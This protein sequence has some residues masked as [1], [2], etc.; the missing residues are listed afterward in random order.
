MEYD[1][2]FV[3]RN[4]YYFVGGFVG[5]FVVYELIKAAG[6]SS[7]SDNTDTSGF[8]NASGGPVNQLQ[9]S[10]DIAASGNNAAIQ[11]ANYHAQ[12]SDN[13]IAAELALG[14]TQAATQLA[15]SL[16][17][18]S[19]TRDVALAQTTADV[20]KTALVTQ[21]AVDIQSIITGG[22]VK[23]TQI[24]GKTLTD[25]SA[26]HIALQTHMLDIVGSQIAQIQAH[27]KH[28]SQDYTAI[29][30]ILAIETGQQSA[31]AA[32]AAANAAD[33]TAASAVKGTAIVAGASVINQ[34]T[35]TSGTVF[36]SIAKGL[37]G[38]GGG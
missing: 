37:F 3:K 31:A 30:P 29:A 24:E 9:A 25:I 21:G 10:A 32:T 36:Q 20:Q 27:S 5:L 16:A 13:A 28:A 1:F 2:G 12:V 19:A 18:T 8:V 4:W 22:E 26:Q 35:R 38:G 6:S 11:T 14:Q 23:Q 34:L 17:T 7:G 33:R 15:E